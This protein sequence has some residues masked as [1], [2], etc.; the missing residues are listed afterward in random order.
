MIIHNIGSKIKTWIEKDLFLDILLAAVVILFGIVSFG[1]GRLSVDVTTHSSRNI[2]VILP[3]G[4]KQGI[5]EYTGS[6]RGDPNIQLQTQIIHS[7]GAFFASKNGT[8]F[9]PKGCSAGNKILETNKIFF[10]T[11]IEATEAGFTLAK[12]C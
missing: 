1:L 5:S 9:Y 10:L 7:D 3:N 4:Q 12:G 11:A 2:E 6:L 8:K